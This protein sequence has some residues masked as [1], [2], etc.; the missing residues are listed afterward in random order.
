MTDKFEYFILKDLLPDEKCLLTQKSFP[1]VGMESLF[2]IWVAFGK[3][4]MAEKKYWKKQLQ[5][6]P[7]CF[8]ADNDLLEYNSWKTG[9][10]KSLQERRK[11]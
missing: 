11:N 10:K 1:A 9:A 6:A 2:A 7:I 3:H 4:V 5:D 8:F